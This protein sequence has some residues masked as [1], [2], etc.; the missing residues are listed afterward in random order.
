M[1]VLIADDNQIGRRLLE[2]FLKPYAE[3]ALAEDGEQAL[4]RYH[5][6][7]ASNTPFDLL[8][9]DVFM[10][11]K[12]GFEVLQEIRGCERERGVSKDSG[13]K[14]LMLTGDG[15]AA[16][17]DQAQLLGVSYYLIK[18]VEE[19]KLLRELQR[20]ELIDDPDDSWG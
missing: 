15:D 18:P 1:R 17:I 9:L 4:E 20:L 11:R 6:A 7:Q 8:V 16:S 3:C 2:L 5:A 19:Y 14:V 10:P 12:N 13:L